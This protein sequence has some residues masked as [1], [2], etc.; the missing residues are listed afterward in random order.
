MAVLTALRK[1]PGAIGRNPILVVLFGSLGLLQAPQMLAQTINPI[2]AILV[3]LLFWVVYIF[4]TPFI[5]AGGIA[6][7]DEA[8]EGRTRI[9]TFIEGGKRNYRSMLGAYL[10]LLAVTIPLGI[11]A[12][13]GFLVAGISVGLA[14]GGAGGLVAIVGWLLLV[15]LA[16]FVIMLFTQFYGQAIVLNDAKAVAGLKQSVSFVRA[17]FA[18]TLGYSVLTGILGGVLGGLLGFSLTV[19]QTTPQAGLEMGTAMPQLPLVNALGLIVVS[20]VFAATM[21][22]LLGVFSVSFYNELRDQSDLADP[23]TA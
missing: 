16:F 11:I 4:V 7:A 15:G 18:S 14:G 9:G 21:G 17:N 22:T 2:V 8:L 10:L 23:A 3:S 19:F 12:F 13:V 6:V 20:M 5:H 1:V